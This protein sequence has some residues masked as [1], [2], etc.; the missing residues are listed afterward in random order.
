MKLVEIAMFV[1]DVDGMAAFYEALLGSPP[2]AR[3]E[4]MAIFMSGATRIFIH[5]TYA[6]GEGELPPEDHTAFEVEDV[7]GECARLA[8][9]GLSVA[10]PAQDYYWGRSVY[11][12]DPAGK[13]IELIQAGSGQ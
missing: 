10:V 2:V 5:Q 4:G 11:L 6:A 9:A 3:S 8:A 13:M 12:R 1:A 7:D